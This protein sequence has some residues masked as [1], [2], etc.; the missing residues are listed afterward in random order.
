MMWLDL[1][2]AFLASRNNTLFTLFTLLYLL[3]FTYPVYL[4]T[5]SV[6]SWAPFIK[7]FL[8]VTLFC[9][10]PQERLDEYNYD[11]PLEGQEML[12][13]DEHWRKHTLSTMEDSLKVHKAVNSCTCNGHQPSWINPKALLI[14]HYIIHIT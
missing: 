7:Q 5:R 14:P 11:K 10:S 13:F 8:D 9:T 6:A 4:S 2:C 1:L 3:Y 12:P